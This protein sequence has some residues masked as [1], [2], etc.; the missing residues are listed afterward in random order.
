MRVLFVT[1]KWPPAVGGM[2][3]YSRELARELDG[4][5]ALTVRKL[6][7]RADGRPP[8]GI[9]L[10][11]FLFGALAHLAAR[12]RR[13]DAVLLG[14]LVLF[15]LAVWT[16]LFARRTAVVQTLHGSDV[17]YDLK[18]GLGPRFYGLYLAV[19]AR[20][21][22]CAD[23]VVANSA[24]TAGHARR[25]GFQDPRTVP[26]G[27]R[28]PASLP[29][30]GHGRN[31]VFVGRVTPQKGVSWLA[32]QVLP[33]LP[34][35]ITL[36]VAGTVWDATE[37][38]TLRQTPRVRLLGPVYGDD[39]ARLRALALAVVVPNLPRETAFEGFGLVALE[40][41]ADGGVVLA[42]E[43]DGLPAAVIDG[44]TG[45]LLPPGD[46]EAWARKI[47]E[48]ASWEADQRAAFVAG[49]RQRVAADF[50]WRR[51]AEETLALC[52]RARV[53]PRSAGTGKIEPM[54]SFFR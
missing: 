4:L 17:A 2:E 48:V 37:A 46:A 27:V 52:A 29:E 21:T 33:R 5:C 44:E 14:D 53:S 26:L 49:A 20:C 39:L 8:G 38:T 7:G 32:E 24:A 47:R 18:R 40:G 30:A 19:V 1:R 25:I 45:F 43:T 3:E 15:P 11:R 10:A 6:P 13:Y 22:E 35:S 23:A 34:E 9:A 41:A 36:D 51:V 12:G 50:T 54:K 28:A 31:L 42:A 16:R